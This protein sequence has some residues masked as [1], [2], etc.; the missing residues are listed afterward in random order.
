MLDEKV[1]CIAAVEDSAKN[2]EGDLAGGG[3]QILFYVRVAG[4]IT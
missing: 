4:L 3:D 2:E 1:G